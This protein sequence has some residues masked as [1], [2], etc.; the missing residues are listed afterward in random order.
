MRAAGD[1]LQDING[2]DPD[3]RAFR[4]TSSVTD[5]LLGRPKRGHDDHNTEARDSQGPARHIDA[6]TVP[7]KQKRLIHHWVTFTSSKLVLLDE[8]QNPCRTMMLP[9]ALKGLVS[10]SNSSNADVA[11]F[12]AICASAA[13]NLY[14][15]GG[16]VCE[17]DHI[18]ALNHDHQAIHHLRHNLAETDA[19][20]AQSVA[21]AIMACIAVEAISGTTQRWRTHVSGGLAYLIRLC[22]QCVDERLLSAFRHHLVKMA[23]LCDVTVPGHLKS[24]LD[25]ESD[26]TVNLEFS[27]P[28]YGVSRS[29][30]RRQDY[31]NSL[32]A[33]SIRSEK[34]ADAFELQLYLD[35]PSISPPGLACMS[36]EAHGLVVHHA[37]KLFYYSQLV[38]FQRSLR[39]ASV[40]AVQDLVGLGVAELESIERLAGHEELGC[41]ML[42]PALILGSESGTLSNQTRVRS[43]FRSQRRLG[44]RNLVVLEDLIVA[45]WK[46]RPDN[47]TENQDV[48]WQKVAAQSPAQF[49]VFR[50]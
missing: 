32:V 38:Y 19:H 47:D 26:A 48:G 6:L 2:V 30:L 29:F 31:I 40:S 4:D 36:N 9:M 27:F 39:G 28:Y 37:A 15:L 1:P 22:S 50:L 45:V 23:I 21:M 44:F 5:T 20:R 43:W 14:E 49:D 12:H 34:E 42:W 33:T 11:I 24:F 16:Q 13:Y 3:L 35:F 8:P 10:V 25:D 41:V 46:A 17:K 18:L 7:S